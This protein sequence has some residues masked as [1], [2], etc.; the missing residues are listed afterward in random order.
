VP[1]TI[2]ILMIRGMVNNQK[3]RKGRKNLI[4]AESNL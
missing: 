4:V 1:E 3:E 2:M